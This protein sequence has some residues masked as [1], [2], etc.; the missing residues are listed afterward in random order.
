[1]KRILLSL[2]LLSTAAPLRADLLFLNNGEELNGTVT[3]V[4]AAGVKIKAGG[5]DLAFPRADILKLQ[6]VKDYSAGAADPLKDPEIARLLA[7][8]PDP[9]AYPN[10]GYITWLNETAIEIAPD[11]S[12]TL[13]RRGLRVVLRERGKSPAAYL[14]HTFLPGIE[15][16][17]IGYAY[18]VTDGKVSY[19]TDV[20][21]MDG[22]PN[23]ATPKY[24]RLK[25]VK[26]AI[27]NVQTGS[28]L[29][30]SYTFENIYASTYPFFADVAFRFSEPVRTARLTVTAPETLKLAWLEFNLPKGTVF[31]KTAK[32]GKAVYIWET[33]ELP[34][35]RS[36]EYNSPPFLRYTPQVLLSLE[37]G[38]E[39]LRS[40]LAPL[41]RE[42]LVITEAMRAK[43]LEL[44]AGR[45]SALEKIE[46]LY[47]WTATEIKYQDVDLEEFSYLPRPS[48]ETFED[49]AGN[50]LD[51]PFLLY[52]L[53]EAAGLKPEFAYVRS[54]NAP[55]A[56]ALA[57]IR[58]FDYA[59]CLVNADG[60]QLALAPLG[61]KRRYSELYASLQGMRAFKALGTGP[62][63]FT[64]PDHTPEEEAE[65]TAAQYTL[66]GDGN[67]SGSY[68]YRMA[69]EGQAAMRGYKDYKKEDMDKSMEKYVHSIHPLARLK[70]YR[71]ENLQDLSRDLEFS[72][73]MEA[74]GYAMKAGKYMILKLPGLSYSAYDAAQT[75][76]ELPL[77]WYARGLD[78][79]EIKLTLPKGYSL[80]HAP[81]P[82]DLKMAGHS[83][84]AAFKSSPGT[85]VFT[86]EFRTEDT[87]VPQAGY[88]D[89]KAFKEALAQF[90]EG[91]I[92]LKKK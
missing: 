26:Y 11:R 18:S 68:S 59:E 48:D 50:A 2:T 53:L 91:W 21:V 90:S 9:K 27:P 62:A 87:W 4:D 55:F 54:K 7:S 33:P 80:Y 57:N 71:L 81:K 16:A 19:L 49:K 78:A 20:S 45:K 10:D 43:A 64:N 38:W 28:V 14:S 3:A 88:P 84:K 40:G 86:D 29:A 76:R 5:K 77:F 34:A 79:R 15:K 83:Y 1:M 92:V 58:Q 73:A 8:P 75:E 72:I 30:Y 69:G 66:D 17:E 13:T 37:G 35:Y 23:L 25:L 12:W 46:A 67:L 63:L 24:D 47:N 82:P 60:R 39:E 41:L 70:G 22:S 56:E 44:T 61:D 85:L 74:P 36:R 51:K 42:R 31:S 52:A 65:R 32:E 6:L 89:Y